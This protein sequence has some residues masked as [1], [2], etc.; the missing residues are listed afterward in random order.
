MSAFP[1]NDENKAKMTLVAEHLQ[2]SCRSL[3]DGLETQFGENASVD[4]FDIELLRHLDDI[5]MCCEGC[6]WWCETHELNDNQQCGDCEPPGE[7]E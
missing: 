2:G 6:Q 3:E 7:A 5:T 4:D 1:Y